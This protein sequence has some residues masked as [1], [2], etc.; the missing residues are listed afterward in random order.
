MNEPPEQPLPVF[1][2]VPEPDGVLQMSWMQ[3]WMLLAPGQ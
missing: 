2:Q 3:H 1:L